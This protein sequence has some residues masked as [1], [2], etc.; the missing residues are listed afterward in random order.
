[1][2][3]WRMRADGSAQEQVTSDQYNTLVFRT[4]PPTAS[5]SPSCRSC[6]TSHPATTRF[7]KPVY[8]RVISGSEAG[9]SHAWSPMYN[10][11]Q[12][13]DQRAVL[14]ADSRRLAFVSN[15][16]LRRFALMASCEPH[17]QAHPSGHRTIGILLG[18]GQSPP[19][20]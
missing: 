18:T 15:T 12:G 9:A 10:G 13:D 16:D 3:I 5:G 11:G 14:V 7:Y 20:S 4:C 1:M 6:R 17:V 2:Q 8:L 19:G